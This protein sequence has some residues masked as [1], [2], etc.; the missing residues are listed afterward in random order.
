MPILEAA[1]CP[2]AI[3][4]ISPAENLELFAQGFGLVGSS[5]EGVLAG[6][7]GCVVGATWA[8][9]PITGQARKI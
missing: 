4:E 1:F 7:R 8:C 2:P 5:S 6:F 9:F 3:I